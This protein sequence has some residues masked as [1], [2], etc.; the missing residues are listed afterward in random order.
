MNHGKQTRHPDAKHDTLLSTLCVKHHECNNCM[1]DGCFRRK[2]PYKMCTTPPLPQPHSPIKGGRNA[3]RSSKGAEMSSD[4]NPMSLD[5]DPMS[6][7][8]DP[9]FELRSAAHITQQVRAHQVHRGTHLETQAFGLVRCPCLHNKLKAIPSPLRNSLEHAGFQP[10]QVLM[11]TQQAQNY[12]KSIEELTGTC[13]LS[14][15]WWPCLLFVL[16]R[17]ER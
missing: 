5:R 11:P 2:R 17:D 9:M 8:R 7:D 14:A 15:W 3:I 12:T 1:R 13:R 10:G 16:Y 6:S 4:R